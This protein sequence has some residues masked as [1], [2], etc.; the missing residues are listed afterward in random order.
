MSLS[1]A[2][3]T[4][5]PVRVVVSS[6]GEAQ[7]VGLLSVS[8]RLAFNRI[9]WAELVIADGDMSEGEF[10]ISD[11]DKFAPGK[12]ISI[13]A[14]FGDS[15]SVVF[16]GIVVR[17]GVTMDGDNHS[18]LVVECRDQ[19]SKMTIGRCNA[20]Y[21]DLTDSDIITKLIGKHGL[22]ATVA[23]TE[24]KHAE[25][26]QYYCSDW[27]FMLAR[28]DANG[29]LVNVSNGAVSV[30]APDTSTDAVLKVTWGM[31][32]L[33]FQADMDA[34]TQLTSA[35]ATAWSHK[36]QAIVQGSKAD[37]KVMNKQ[38]NLTGAMLAKVASPSNYV[39]QTSTPQEQ[40]VLTSWAAAAQ[41][42]AAL[43]RIRGHMSFIGSALPKPGCL[44]EAVGVGARFK[45][46]VF[47][48][49]VE[50]RMT[51]GM[52]TTEVQFGL[53]PVW[54]VELP[55]VMAPVN[56]G[57]LPGVT[58]LQIGVVMKLDE[59]P[60]GEQRIQV[61]LPVMQAETEGIWARLL[62]PYASNAFGFFFLPEVGDEVL[63]G[64]LNDDPCHPMV[65]G[66]LYS[67]AR[68]P[69]YAL[70]A[71]NNTKAIVTRSKHKIEFNEADKIITITTPGNNKVVLDDTGKSILVQDQ[72][73]NSV[74][75]SDSGIALD[76]PYDI[77]L[78][79]KG[80][81]TLSAVSSIKLEAQA[82]VKAMGLNVNCE[83]Q[84]GFVGKGSAT[85]EVSAAGQTTIKGAMVMI[86]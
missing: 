41:Q 81:I 5:G 17:H 66:S 35:Q 67:S 25:L 26:V 71:A 78:S 22:S 3:N 62:Q 51:N 53:D 43:A 28:A 83:A 60:L 84:V 4:E 56:G 52:W 18:R 58:G 29:L 44:I 72:N 70:E 34:R 74:K 64:Y 57:L 73:N 46:P 69:P 59:D 11:G 61:K 7:T 27:D 75:L 1:P 63:I 54:Q 13:S 6:D 68:T 36:N 86:N 9:P 39:L 23:S 80:G 32:L 15:E 31:D 8:I 85:A 38:G 79:A 12:V 40:A 2:Q 48:S 55:D 37:P 24:N 42:K 76:S 33:A 49:A 10:P 14:G 77:K 20:N 47:V 50:H 65:L 21:E 82:D 45:G 16:S 30:K 19:A